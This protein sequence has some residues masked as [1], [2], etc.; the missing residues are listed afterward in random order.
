MKLKGG[1]RDLFR[2]RQ[3]DYRII[4]E[5]HDDEII[6]MVVKVGHRRHVYAGL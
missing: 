1:E 6:V 2:A 4:Y 3:G 5:V